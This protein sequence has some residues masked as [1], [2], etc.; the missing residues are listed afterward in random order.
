MRGISRYIV[1]VLL[2]TIRR[3]GRRTVQLIAPA[4]ATSLSR[5][6]LSSPGSQTNMRRAAMLTLATYSA[7][8]I[9]YDTAEKMT[10]F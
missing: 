1:D 9:S 3:D 4:R 6:G 7:P 8:L 5:I 10:L 2:A